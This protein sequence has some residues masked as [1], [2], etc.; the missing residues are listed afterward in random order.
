MGARVLF[1]PRRRSR[2]NPGQPHELLCRAL[3]LATVLVGVALG[4]SALAEA[5]LRPEEAASHVGEEA[6][7]CGRVVSTH[8]A[9]RSRGRPTFL[10]LDRP[11]PNHVFTVVI[12][13]DDRP[14]FPT[15]PEEL[16]G[17]RVCVHGRITSYRGRPQIVVTKPDQIRQSPEDR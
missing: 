16:F 13:G 12:W 2:P 15:P 11:Y 10:N 14:H 17:E 4:G 7:V 8:Y 3:A 6:T 5:P 9:E 1:A